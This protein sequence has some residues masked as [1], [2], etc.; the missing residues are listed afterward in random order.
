MKAGFLLSLTEPGLLFEAAAHLSHARALAAADAATPERER[1]HIEALQRVL[2]GRWGSACRL[3]DALLVQHPRDAL[4]LQWVHLWDFYRGDLPA[5]RQRPARALPEWDEHDPLQPFVLGLLAFGL[6]ENNLYPQAEEAGRRALAANPRMPWAIH[7]VVHVMEMQGRFEDGAAWLRQT[8]PH[9]AQGNGF[10][11]HLWWHKALFRL[12]S[13]DTAG[14]LRLVDSHLSGDA[15]QTSL[16]RVDAASVL[17]RL[18]LLGED[19][20]GRCAALVASWPLLNGVSAAGA[21]PDVRGAGDRIRSRMVHTHQA[22]GGGGQCTLGEG[23]G[24]G[25]GGNGPGRGARCRVRGGKL[26]NDD[27]GVSCGGNRPGRGARCRA[28]SEPYPVGCVRQYAF[29][30]TTRRGDG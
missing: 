12:E 16:E 29:S 1:V 27:G 8:Q 20:R 4:A 22:H 26:R 17:W 28:G 30:D 7:A 11:A 6:E 25:Y 15:L 2:E 14:A 23:E 5:L 24:V 19:V 3:W 9:W 13:L 18:H 10:G 21:A